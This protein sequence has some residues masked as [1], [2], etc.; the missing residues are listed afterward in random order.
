M[1]LQGRTSLPTGQ[2]QLDLSLQTAPATGGLPAPAQN[3]LHLLSVQ[4]GKDEE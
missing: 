2:Q 3:C 4:F 1:I